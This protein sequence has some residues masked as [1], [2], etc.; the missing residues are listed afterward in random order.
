MA[1]VYATVEEI[2]AELGQDIERP[3]PD[4]TMI[5]RKAI[6]AS[7]FIDGYC[8]RRFYPEYATYN[9][10]HPVDSTRALILDRDLLSVSSLT[11][12]ATATTITSANYFL[13]SGNSSNRTPYNCIV[14]DNNDSTWEYSETMTDANAVTGIWGYHND[15]SNAWEH[16]DDVQDSPLL[17]G[18]TSLTVADAD[19]VDKRGLKPRFQ[20]G[21]LIRFGATAT[22]E[23]AHITEISAETLTIVRGV[24]GSTAAEQAND[25][26]IYVYRPQYDIMQAALFLAMHLYR[27]KDSV[28][29][30]TDQPIASPSGVILSANIP[31]E[32]VTVLDRYILRYP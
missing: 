27:R 14:L 2:K 5:R 7:R 6:E 22:A 9:Y 29:A 3:E 11:T 10:D 13:K 26:D 20:V 1:N 30:L 25:I 24:N 21:Q 16:V 32:V 31:R 12:D 28:G 4:D 18:G 19:G 15:W 8:R 17:V 23:Y